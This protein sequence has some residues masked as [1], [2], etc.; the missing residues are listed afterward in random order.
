MGDGEEG[1]PGRAGGSSDD[2]GKGTQGGTRDEGGV[3][4]RSKR[5]GA[6]PHCEL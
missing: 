6:N 2:V 3:S 5:S 4:D 1:A